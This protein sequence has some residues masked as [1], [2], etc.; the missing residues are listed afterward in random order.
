MHAWEDLEDCFSGSNDFIVFSMQQEIAMLM[1]EDKSIAQYYNK[2]IPFW[3]DEDALTEEI[4]CELGSRC[5]A[6]RCY[7]DRKIRDRRVK[8]LM[9]LNEVYTTTS[10]RTG[11]K[12][13]TGCHEAYAAPISSLQMTQEQ[14]NKLMMFPGDSGAHTTDQIVG[15]TCLSSVKVSQDT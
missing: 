15:I 3:G 11:D 9:G 1:Q 6:T 8:F 4:A 5:K 14:L 7:T 13:H 10:A 2:F 12:E